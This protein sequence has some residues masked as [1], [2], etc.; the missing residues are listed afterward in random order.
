M[1]VFDTSAVLAILYDEEGREV[2]QDRLEGSAISAVNLAEVL[3]DVMLT[4][5]ENVEG[6]YSLVNRLPLTVYSPDTSQAKRVAE[7]KAIKGLSLGD[8]FCIALGEARRS[9]LITGDQQWGRLSA[10]IRVPVE[11][12]R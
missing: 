10:D 7:L 2:A 12:I 5:G 1:N 9:P 6:A 8:C 11:M 4:S 3:R